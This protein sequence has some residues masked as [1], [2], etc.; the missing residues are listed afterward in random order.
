M[1]V[2]VNFFNNKDKKSITF[3]HIETGKAYQRQSDGLVIYRNCEHYL[4]IY[5]SGMINTLCNPRGLDGLFVEVD[6][7]FKISAK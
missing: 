1:A 3:S 6:L 4:Y 5:P 7:E 2:R